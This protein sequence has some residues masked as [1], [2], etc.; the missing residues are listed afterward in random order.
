MTLEIRAQNLIAA[1]QH[2]ADARQSRAYA[3]P[4][5]ALAADVFLEQAQAEL[6]TFALLFTAAMIRE[7]GEC[8][9]E[10]MAQFVEYVAGFAESLVVNVR[11]GDEP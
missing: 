8:E 6:K 10:W 5:R 7:S 3:T 4:H 2:L 11:Q 1:A 9:T